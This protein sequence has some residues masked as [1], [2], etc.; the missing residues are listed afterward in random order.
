MKTLLALLIA[1]S[2]IAL[3]VGKA[4]AGFIGIGV[5]AFAL[6]ASRQFAE[7]HSWRRPAAYSGR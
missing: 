6:F 1:I 2:I 7:K 5:A 3:C 4:P